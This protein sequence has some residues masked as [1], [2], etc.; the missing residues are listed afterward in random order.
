MKT[1][2]RDTGPLANSTL[3]WGSYESGSKRMSSDGKFVLHFPRIEGIYLRIRLCTMGPSESFCTRHAPQAHASK[4]QLQAAAGC[5]EG[6]YAR[7]RVR[8]FCTLSGV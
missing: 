4:E 5:L 1:G 2:L 6:I 7:A 8:A 3:P